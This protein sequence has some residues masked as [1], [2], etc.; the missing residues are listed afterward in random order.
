[1]PYTIEWKTSGIQSRFYGNVIGA[2]IIDHVKEWHGDERFDSV[3]FIVVNF[4]DA[5]Q[6]SIT[7]DEVREIA[8]LDNVAALSNPRVKV[9]VVSGS[10]TVDAGGAVYKAGLADSPWKTESFR[11]VEEALEWVAE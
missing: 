6:V 4:L 2:E 7:L 10:E 11:T 3:R 5:Q 8:A 9:A 1:M